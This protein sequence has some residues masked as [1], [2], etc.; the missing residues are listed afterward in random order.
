LGEDFRAF[1]APFFSIPPS[2]AATM[3]PLQRGVLETTYRAL[4]NGSYF[5]VD[6][7]GEEHAVTS[8]QLVYPSKQSKDQKRLSMLDLSQTTSIL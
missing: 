2:E 8:C 6:F 4:E 1:D 3:D 7:Q 5:R